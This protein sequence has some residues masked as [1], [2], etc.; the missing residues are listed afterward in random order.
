MHNEHII[1]LQVSVFLNS[2]QDLQL[3]LVLYDL[4][5]CWRNFVAKIVTELAPIVYILISWLIINFMKQELSKKVY[6]TKQ[7]VGNACGTV[8]IIHAL[9]NAASKIMLGICR[10]FELVFSKWSIEYYWLHA[11]E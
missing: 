8:G 3:N 5:L 2:M 4:N 7:T 6:F 1:W 9:G 10:S 11:S